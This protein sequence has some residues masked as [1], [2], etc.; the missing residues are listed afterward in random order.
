MDSLEH[1]LRSES[2]LHNLVFQPQNEVQRSPIDPC[3][4][5]AQACPKACFL[6]LL[7]MKDSGLFPAASADSGYVTSYRHPLARS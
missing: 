1:P 5:G 3:P 6:W 2:A 4:A 7:T